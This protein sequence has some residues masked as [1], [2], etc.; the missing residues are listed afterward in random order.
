LLV[1]EV[2]V[3]LVILHLDLLAELAVAVGVQLL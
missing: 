2:E 1:V 3:L